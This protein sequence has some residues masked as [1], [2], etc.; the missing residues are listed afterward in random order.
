MADYTAKK[1]SVTWTVKNNGTGI[2]KNVLITSST[3]TYAPIS[4]IPGWAGI[5]DI[6][7]GGTGSTVIQYQM[8]TIG[9]GFR[10]VNVATAQDCS[11]A[12]YTYP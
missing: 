1:L 12:S 9:S 3:P 10:V 5:G 8:T 2:A 7:A 11:G 6:A 4:S